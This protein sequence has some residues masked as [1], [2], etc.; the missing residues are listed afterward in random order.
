MDK[1]K[2]LA[3]LLLALMLLGSLCATA[4]ADAVFDGTVT[5]SETATVFAP[6]GGTIKSI[7]LREGQW[8]DENDVVATIETTKVFAT[9]DGTVRGVFALPGDSAEGTVLYIAPVNKYKI[10]ANLEK[11]Y[12]STATKYVRL[13]EKVYISCSKDGTHQAVGIITSVTGSDYTVET[14][15]GE[16]YLEETVYIYRDP[17]YTTASRIG[18]G[19]VARTGEIAVAGTGSV[20][21]LH[22][23]DGEEVERGQLL[24][25]TVE[26]SIDALNVTDGAVISPTSGVVASIKA[27]AGAKI[28]KGGALLT[29]YPRTTYQIEMTVPEDMLSS[30]SEG[31]EVT[32]YFNWIEDAQRSYT[33]TIESVSYLD[34]A[35]SKADNSGDSNTGENG[36]TGD[37]TSG[38]GGDTGSSDS[39]EVTYKA[40]VNF[41]ADDSVRV[42]MSVTV[43]LP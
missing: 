42:G 15:G 23:R 14:T 1:R 30:I 37:G 31:D 39:D 22:V 27:K 33:G 11:A 40:Y 2:A 41:E 32:I 26:G 8:V 4:G 9:E 28:E 17:A 36:T 24:F 29:I 7:D 38:D 35:S 3:A 18:S 21:K 20:L 12:S 16:L 34:T 5:A 25:E 13:G 43:S 6:Y 10:S 19:S